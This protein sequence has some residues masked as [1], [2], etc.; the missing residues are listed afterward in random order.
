[1]V[2]CRTNEKET[3]SGFCLPGPSEL[4]YQTSKREQK[5]GRVPKAVMIHRGPQELN[6][7]PSRQ[8]TQCR[9]IINSPEC[10]SPRVL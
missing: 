10:E 3:G 6:A 5:R 4:A 2:T 1:M 7:Q 9:S 8:T